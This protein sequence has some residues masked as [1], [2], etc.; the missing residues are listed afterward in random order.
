S[1]APDFANTIEA[2]EYAGAALEQVQSVFQNLN[3]SLTSPELQKIAQELAPELSS[4]R[5]AIR[6]NPALFQRVKSVY[7]S[8][9]QLDLA[10][11][12]AKLLDETYKYFVRGGANLS[13]DDKDKLRKINEELSILSL[14]FGQNVLAETNHYKLVIE[15]EGDLAGLPE[16]VKSAAAETASEAGQEGKWIFTVQ[17]PSMLPFLTYADNRD[18]REQLHKAY[19]N[20]GDNDNDYDNKEII[21]KI[22][23]LR[24][25]KAKIMGYETHAHFILE[26]N[27]AKTPDKVYEFLRKVWEPGLAVAKKEV[28]DLQKMILDEGHNFEL[29]H[30]DWWYYSEKLRKAKYD[31]DEET[32]S[33]YFVLDNVRNG[34]FKLATNLFGLQFEERLDIPKYHP[35]VQVFEVKDAAG[36]HIGILYMDFH[37]RASKRSGAWMSE[38]R[39]Q[40]ILNGK[41]IRPVVT[42]NFNF[43][44]PTGETPALLTM[45]EVLTTFHEFGHALHGLLSKC[46]Y[47]SLAG[48]SVSR[49]FVELPSQIMENW[50][51]EPEVLRTYAFHYKTGEEIPQQL[52]DKIKASS[53]FNQGFTTT[54]YMSATFLDMD[55]HTLTPE[56]AVIEVRD[57]ENNSMKNIGLIDEIIVRYRSSYF[58]HIFAGG[59]SAGYYAYIWAEVLDSDAFN[60]F[61]ETGNL[62]DP[63]T[64]DAFRT[65][66]LEKGGTEDPMNLYMKFR[67][68]E[69]DEKALLRKR[70]LL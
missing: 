8:R 29:E 50:A 49:D 70:G 27:M 52:I 64:A 36:G 3:S 10:T 9:D 34:A 41:D 54:E 15:N 56:N 59:Y 13:E 14:K 39:G 42:T 55:Y 26:E 4:H 30:W 21:K 20:L 22:V 43:T 19:I 51:M 69:P 18:L 45:D 61:K 38:Y 33:Q 47:G 62:Y 60:A 11:E 40:K 12:Q 25:E 2:L 17:K 44:K 46:T 5:D 65:N 16:G 48:T 23:K 58:S 7:D 67:G 66:I 53:N 6:M 32:I 68:K 31:L 35:D 57:F 1:E 63:A 28:K 37:P 24:A